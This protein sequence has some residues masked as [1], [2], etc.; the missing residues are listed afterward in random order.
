MDRL[1]HPRILIPL[2]VAV[3]LTGGAVLGWGITGFEGYTKYPSEEVA[4]SGASGEMD[5]LFAE[6]GINEELGETEQLENKFAL[7]LLPS[8]PGRDSLS[9]AVIAALSAGIIVAAFLLDWRMRKKESAGSGE[10]ES[11]SS[12]Q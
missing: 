7:G 12:G 9:V 11:A 5:D 3:V 8:G 4:Q 1:K 6:T 10:S 2:L